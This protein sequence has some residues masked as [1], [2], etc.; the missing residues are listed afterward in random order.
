MYLDIT[1]R[2][3]AQVV[4]RIYVCHGCAKRSRRQQRLVA[5]PKNWESRLEPVYNKCGVRQFRGGFVTHY[6]CPCCVH[7][8]VSAATDAAATR[9]RLRKRIST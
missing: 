7:A 1:D 9:K 8:G 6:Y 4:G 2:T 3:T 5:L